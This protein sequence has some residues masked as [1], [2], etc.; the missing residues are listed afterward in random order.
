MR[1]RSIETVPVALPFR[2]QYVTASGALESREMLIL[3]IISDD[4]ETGHGDAVPMSLRGGPGLDEIRNQLEGPCRAVLESASLDTTHPPGEAGASIRPIVDACAAAGAGPGAVAAVDIALIDLVA[5]AWGVPAWVV[6]GA[7]AARPVRCNGTVGADQ[8][9]AVAARGRELAQRGFD[10]LKVKVGAG[11]DA[12][13]LQALR[14][15]CGAE[16]AL[17]IDANGAW[18]LEEASGTLE[19]LD[20]IGLELA[21]QPCPTLEDLAELRRRTTTPLVADESVSSESEAA[22]AMELAACDAVTLKLA[23][24][25]G[26][27]AA[28][29]IAF[30]AP[31]YLS[32]ALDSPL[33]IAAAAHTVQAMPAHGFVGGLAH[34]LATSELF[35]DNVADDAGLEGPVIELHSAPGLGVEIDEPAMER[36][37][38]R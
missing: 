13:R 8:P 29:R 2:E 1:I 12:G 11:D 31:A 35:A 26:P 10:T 5:R 25:G 16:V 30:R 6:L 18:E 21:E 24:V 3:R 9:D 22:R 32:S 33:G 20:P 38:I 36:L 7:P 15:V 14:D 34:G 19:A 37:R 4:G 27:H 17:R 28:L 23:K